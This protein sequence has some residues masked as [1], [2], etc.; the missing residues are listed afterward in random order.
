MFDLDVVRNFLTCLHELRLVEVRDVSKSLRHELFELRVEQVEV[1]VE[2]LLRREELRSGE[3]PVPARDDT[4]A[5]PR[6]IAL[7]T[8]STASRGIAS[9]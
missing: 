3:E 1:V 6:R 9:R 4:V 5:T 7:T 2:L 8:T